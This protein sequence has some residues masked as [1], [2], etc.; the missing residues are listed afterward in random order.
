M[1]LVFW[2]AAAFLVAGAWLVRRFWG[3]RA[4][5]ITAVIVLVP[6]ALFAL[7]FLFDLVRAFTIGCPY[8]SA[9]ACRG[10]AVGW[11]LTLALIVLI[12]V[13]NTVAL[14]KKSAVQAKA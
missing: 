13:P 12:L 1:M 5:K 7:V 11:Q 4:S 10:L 9:G 14:L 6:V 8:D 2:S 3:V